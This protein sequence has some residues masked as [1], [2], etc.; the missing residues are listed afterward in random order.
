M[1]GDERL[2]MILHDWW[3]NEPVPDDILSETAALDDMRSLIAHLQK[4]GY[5]IV[6]YEA[7]A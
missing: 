2:A 7:V 4:F 6:P 1:T 3:W 5:V